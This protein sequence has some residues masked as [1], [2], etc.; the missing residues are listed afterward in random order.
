[1]NNQVAHRRN[2]AQHGWHLAG[3]EGPRAWHE[4]AP[5]AGGTHRGARGC[6][7]AS[8]L[9]QGWP[10][11][12][13]SGRGCSQVLLRDTRMLGASGSTGS[14]HLGWAAGEIKKRAESREGNPQDPARVLPD[15]SS[16]RNEGSGSILTLVA[17]EVVNHFEVRSLRG[18]RTGEQ[19]CR[20]AGNVMAASVTPQ[21]P[22][23]LEFV[24][25]VRSPGGAT[26]VVAQ[27]LRNVL[28]M[29]SDTLVLSA[30]PI[31]SPT[32]APR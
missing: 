20:C 19:K 8:S 32:V 4:R 27:N 7:Y 12:R 18:K 31:A 30:H 2:Q 5:A 17:A 11:E 21:L 26:Y 22:N 10:G 14:C 3:T 24:G 16:R 9:A 29:S 23:R 6:Q 15:R 25:P 1:M 28:G 13:Y